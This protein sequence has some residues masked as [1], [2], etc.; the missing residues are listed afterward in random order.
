MLFKTSEDKRIRV[1]LIRSQFLPVIPSKLFVY[2]SFKHEINEKEMFLQHEY[3]DFDDVAKLIAFRVLSSFCSS[4]E[5]MIHVFTIHLREMMS[6]NFD[7]L[8]SAGEIKEMCLDT[9]VKTTY[10]S[11]VKRRRYQACTFLMN[12]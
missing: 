10:E 1:M 6:D 2:K 11:F 3:E 8:L 5:S 4:L 12:N 7:K 9:I